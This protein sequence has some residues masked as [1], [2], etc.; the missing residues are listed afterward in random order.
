[1]RDFGFLSQRR[2]RFGDKDGEGS[3]DPE[4]AAEETTRGEEAY[5]SF[6]PEAGRESIWLC[7]CVTR[8]GAINDGRAET[9]SPDSREIRRGAGRLLDLFLMGEAVAPSTERS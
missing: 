7:V 5:A 1:M 9:R 2:L 8:A 6:L 4:A 3:A